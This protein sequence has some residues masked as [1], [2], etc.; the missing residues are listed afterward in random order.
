MVDTRIESYVIAKT[1][2]ATYR[3][4]ISSVLFQTSAQC[5]FVRLSRAICFWLALVRLNKFSKS[6]RS[7]HLHECPGNDT[8]SQARTGDSPPAATTSPRPAQ[9]NNKNQTNK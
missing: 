2:R 7:A 6:R 9:I 4:L 3:A 1:V 8:K 5:S